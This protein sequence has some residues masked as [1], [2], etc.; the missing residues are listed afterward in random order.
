MKPDALYIEVLLVYLFGRATT[1]KKSWTNLI[2]STNLIFISHD[3]LYEEIF[4]DKF[5]CYVC[6]KN[7]Q[8]SVSQGALFQSYIMPAFGQGKAVRVYRPCTVAKENLTSDTRNTS[9]VLANKR[10]SPLDVR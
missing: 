5:S 8:F 1:D 9:V 7:G 6:G 2:Y 10:R 3:E 4:L